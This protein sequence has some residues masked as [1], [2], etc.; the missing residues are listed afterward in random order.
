MSLLLAMSTKMIL[1]ADWPERSW[2]Q[3]LESPMFEDSVWEWQVVKV[4]QN[5]PI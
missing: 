1:F 2:G 4:V 5:P 3:L